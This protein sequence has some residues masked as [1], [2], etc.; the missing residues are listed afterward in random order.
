MGQQ[1]HGGRMEYQEHSPEGENRRDESPE[2]QEM[3]N[4]LEGGVSSGAAATQLQICLY[5][6]LG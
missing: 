1:L 3:G 6:V 2:A 5:H 4:S